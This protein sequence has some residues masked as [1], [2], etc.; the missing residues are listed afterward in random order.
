MQTL[1][2]LKLSGSHGKLLLAR[3]INNKV[4]RAIVQR[5]SPIKT[6][7]YR[8]S[9][10]S[11]CGNVVKREMQKSQRDSSLKS[12]LSFLRMVAC[13]LR[14]HEPSFVPFF[15]AIFRILPG[16]HCKLDFSLSEL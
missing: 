2:A 9:L 8:I 15:R 5:L 12:L 16:I 10:I 4:M 6:L 7:C 11:Q 14:S 3:I 1:D 13:F